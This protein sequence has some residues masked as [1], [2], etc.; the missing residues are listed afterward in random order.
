MKKVFPEQIEL[1]RV[2]LTRNVSTDAEEIF[3]AYASKPEATRFLSWPTHEQLS[4]TRDFLRFAQATWKERT[5]FTFSVRVK[6][7]NR[8]IGGCGCIHRDGVFQLGYVFSPSVWGHGYATEVCQGLTSEILKFPGLRR[9][10]SFVDVD[11]PTSAR[12]L[13][14]SGFI[15]EQLA[16][17]FFVPVNQGNQKK[18]AYIFVYPLGD[19]TAQV[20]K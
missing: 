8:L 19:I 4:D 17:D 10:C 11:N 16:P 5:Q 12:V 13:E 15:K 3:Y 9:L 14:K 7:T 1:T 18:D 6:T 2:R 20:I